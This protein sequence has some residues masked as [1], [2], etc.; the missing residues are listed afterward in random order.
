[1][2]AHVQTF[3]KMRRNTDII[4]AGHE[5]FRQ[6]VV[7]NPLT[8]NDFHFLGIKRGGIILKILHDSP[9]FW[10]FIKNFSFA[11]IDFDA[12][13][14]FI[15]FYIREPSLSRCA[16]HSIWV[17]LLQAPPCSL[18]VCA[19]ADRGTIST[20]PTHSVPIGGERHP[21]FG[22]EFIILLRNMHLFHVYLRD[23][24]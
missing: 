24:A 22:Q 18:K 7:Q 15:S 13:R 20:N 6:T 14:H 16:P 12:P 21:A 17:E 19:R 1:M 11:F 9:R 10:P 4:Q 2:F 23:N 8:V 3:E 5:E